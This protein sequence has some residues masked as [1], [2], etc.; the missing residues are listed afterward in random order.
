MTPNHVDGTNPRKEL[1]LLPRDMDEFDRAVA[2][3]MR[4]TSWAPGTRCPT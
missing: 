3:N 1:D 2:L 4:S